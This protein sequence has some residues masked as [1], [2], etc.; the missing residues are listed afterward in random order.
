MLADGLTKQKA[1]GKD[2][3]KSIMSN[4]WTV[5]TV[6]QG[7]EMTKEMMAEWGIADSSDEISSVREVSPPMREMAN[8]RSVDSQQ[9]K[10]CEI[11]N[12]KTEQM[13]VQDPQVGPRR[14][15]IGSKKMDCWSV[16]RMSSGGKAARR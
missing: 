2:L 8:V 1:G 16:Q 5:K 10:K 11:L 14:I 12:K 15:S 3:R 7:G 13:V 4:R 9:K 6:D